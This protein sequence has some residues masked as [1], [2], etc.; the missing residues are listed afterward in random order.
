M[1]RIYLKRIIF[2]LITL[3][4]II[5]ILIW[6]API[7]KHILPAPSPRKLNKIFMDNQEEFEQI[8]SF[9]SELPYSNISIYSDDEK[10]YMNVC[11]NEHS[12]FKTEMINNDIINESLEKL[13]R[14]NIIYLVKKTDNTVYFPCWSAIRDRACGI[15]YTIDNLNPKIEFMIYY[16]ELE[17]KNWYYYYVDFDK[18]KILEEKGDETMNGA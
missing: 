9:F 3:S 8:A 11:L 4:I 1:K 10:G 17:I 13:F 16:S 2:I 6:L 15:A 18:Y 14:K 12:N 7:I 5:I